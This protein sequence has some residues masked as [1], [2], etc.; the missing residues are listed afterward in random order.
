MGLA[1]QFGGDMARP[2]LGHCLFTQAHIEAV[3]YIYHTL[4]M[5]G[6]TPFQRFLTFS[7][8]FLARTNL[9]PNR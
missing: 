6:N 1:E 7:E 5:E 3:K 8:D 2:L 9:D 4:T